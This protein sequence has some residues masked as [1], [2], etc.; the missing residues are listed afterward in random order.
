MP[1]AASPLLWVGRVQGA[2]QLKDVPEAV[3]LTVAVS[4]PGVYS[5]VQGLQIDAKIM[6]ENVKVTSPKIEYTLI[7]DHTDV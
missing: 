3:H 6:G 7:V 5:L 2:V 1:E 4:R